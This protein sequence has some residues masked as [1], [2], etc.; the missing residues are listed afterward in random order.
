MVV[1][2]L[3]FPHGGT[4][5]G[6]PAGSS[7]SL[8]DRPVVTTPSDGTGAHGC[9]RRWDSDLDG[10]RRCGFWRICRV[11]AHR[12]IVDNSNTSNKSRRGL[13]SPLA[14]RMSQEFDPIPSQS[15]PCQLWRNQ[16]TMHRGMMPQ[17]RRDRR[18]S[19]HYLCRS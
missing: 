5:T 14:L 1:R 9:A 19:S 12:G 2:T 10:R 18:G 15:V 4:C 3:S 6:P 7:R 8:Q 11:F 13:I 16:A 17:A